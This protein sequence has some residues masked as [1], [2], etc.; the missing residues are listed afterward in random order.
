M[1]DRSQTWRQWET[2]TVDGCTVRFRSRSEQVENWWETEVFQVTDGTRTWT[3]SAYFS[4]DET[5]RYS[6]ADITVTDSPH[7]KLNGC[8]HACS[9]EAF[10]VFAWPILI[11]HTKCP[12]QLGR[13]EA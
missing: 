7:F 10:V 12:D 5:S 9:L 1:H 2:I 13:I 3:G 8:E 4:L 6:V 11:G